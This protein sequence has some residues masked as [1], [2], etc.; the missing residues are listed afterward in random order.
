MGEISVPLMRYIQ[1]TSPFNATRVYQ[2]MGNIGIGDSDSQ[3]NKV[4]LDISGYFTTGQDASGE[5]FLF[6]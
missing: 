2:H 1:N 4:Y 3:T 5:V 6:R